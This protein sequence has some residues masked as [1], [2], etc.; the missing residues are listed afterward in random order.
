MIID[1]YARKH[2][3]WGIF[4]KGIIE[5]GDLLRAG[6]ELAAMATEALNGPGSVSEGFRADTVEALGMFH[7]ASM[8]QERA[9]NARS[10]VRPNNGVFIAV[11]PL[12]SM[13]EDARRL[14]PYIIRHESSKTTLYAAA[15]VACD[16]QIFNGTA[17][18]ETVVMTEINVKRRRP[19]YAHFNYDNNHNAPTIIEAINAADNAAR[20]WWARM[21]KEWNPA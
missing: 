21:M 18:G 1:N 13:L 19:H 20:E 14:S 17:A 16:L 2:R 12:I 10:V 3:E 5:E 7:A 4:I 11:L 15:D 6:R 9:N 8:A